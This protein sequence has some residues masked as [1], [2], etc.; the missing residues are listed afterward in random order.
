MQAAPACCCEI[1]SEPVKSTFFETMKS[2]K[3]Y[4]IAIQVARATIAVFGLLMSPVSFVASFAVGTI[5]GAL[6]YRH[7][8]E[9]LDALETLPMCARGY[10]EMLGQAKFPPIVNLGITTITLLACISCHT[11][12]YA[13]FSGFFIGFY[14]GQKGGEQIFSIQE[15]GL[16]EIK[17]FLVDL[18][19][20]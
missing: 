4:D 13:P 3:A 18:N 10:A 15:G 12:F 20:I 2:K 9:M 11:A 17:P 7:N 6:Y 16:P 5:A 8:N 14:I 19:K 1:K